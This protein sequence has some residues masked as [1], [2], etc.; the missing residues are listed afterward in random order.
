MELLIAWQGYRF[1]QMEANKGFRH[2]AATGLDPRC[3]SGA[4]SG[5]SV[6]PGSVRGG[7]GRKARPGKWIR[8]ICRKP[9]FDCFF[10]A[11]WPMASSQEDYWQRN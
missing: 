5:K 4:T 6:V 8:R 7:V 3:R 11:F 9:T 2:C 1:W 10:A